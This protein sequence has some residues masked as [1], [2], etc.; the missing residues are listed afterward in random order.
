MSGPRLMQCEICGKSP[1]DGKTAIFRINSKGEDGIWRCE[2]HLK[3][4]KVDPEVLWLV[5][6]I[7]PKK[8]V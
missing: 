2:E 1:S 7:Q 3:E 5:D 4:H 6:A 8:E